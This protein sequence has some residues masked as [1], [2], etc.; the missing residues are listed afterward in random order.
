M[1]RDRVEDDEVNL[2]PGP[3]SGYSI[4]PFEIDDIP[5]PPVRPPRSCEKTLN[6]QSSEKDAEKNVDD[7]GIE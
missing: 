3:K 2:D 1:S 4:P 7:V 6:K 5:M